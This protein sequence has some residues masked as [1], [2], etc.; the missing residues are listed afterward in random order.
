M[1][2][3]TSPLEEDVESFL[4]H[5]RSHRGASQHTLA[6]YRRDLNQV[7]HFFSVRGIRQWSDLQTKDF[8]AYS[9]TLGPPLAASSA[10]RKMSSLRSLIKFLAK[11]GGKAS[12]EL[13]AVSGFKRK[14]SIPKA[15]S[16]EALDNLLNQIPVDTPIGLRDRCLF[17]LIYGTGLRISEAIEL[18]FDALDIENS[19]IR[20]TGKRDKTRWIPLPEA[21]LVWLQAYMNRARP[22]LQ[23]KPMDRIFLSERG[24]ALRRTTAALQLAKY[25]KLAGMERPPSPHVLRHSYAVHLLR[26]GADLRVV[27][28][29]L[30]HESIATTQIYTQLDLD[31]VRTNYAKAHPRK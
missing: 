7:I 13:P 27:Q 28:E 4:A 12:L 26:G 18:S 17:E 25:A 20:V 21:T 19:A 3:Q 24:L 10:Q 15:L 5:M 1:E 29:L 2:T 22:L 6:A 16:L 11:R 9:E 31:A 14:R 23:K 8:D 30:G